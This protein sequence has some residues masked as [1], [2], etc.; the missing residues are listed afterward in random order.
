MD[1]QGLRGRAVATA[2]Q[3][4]KQ[5]RNRRNRMLVC[6][7][8]IS[9]PF[10]SAWARLCLLDAA[11][12]YVILSS[13]R[14]KQFAE[15]SQSV[16]LPPCVDWP[17]AVARTATPIESRSMVASLKRLPDSSEALR[18]RRTAAERRRLRDAGH[19]TAPPND[20]SSA[21]LLSSRTHRPRT[22]RKNEGCECQRC[23]SIGRVN[24]RTLSAGISPV[25]RFLAEAGNFGD[26]TLGSRLHGRLKSPSGWLR[27]NAVFICP[28]LVVD[29]RPM[30]AA[31]RARN[32][33]SRART[34]GEAITMT[35]AVGGQSM[36]TVP[37]R[38]RHAWSPAFEVHHGR[39]IVSMATCS[40]P[41]APP[42]RNQSIRR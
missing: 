9:R 19:R 34:A 40:Q 41:A 38:R 1:C 12:R 23:R 24:K 26:A 5:Y 8:L 42:R 28:G 37:Q 13:R 25:N 27:R 14:R 29:S 39:S 4:V 35:D 3:K 6:R 32:A 15:S 11:D 33:T 17:I 20:P 18:A 30:F 36:D 2:T 22:P 10:S 21:V 7:W 16:A 31:T